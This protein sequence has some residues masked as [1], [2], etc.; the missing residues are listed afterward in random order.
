MTSRAALVRDEI[1][2]QHD[3][4]RTRLEDIRRAAEVVVRAR[5]GQAPDLPAMLEQLVGA[6]TA[7]M[8][9]EN[10]HLTPLLQGRNPCGHRYAALL[11]EEHVRQREELLAIVRQATDPDDLISLALAVAAFAAD[12]VED[13]DEE[14]LQFLTPHLLAEGEDDDQHGPPPQRHVGR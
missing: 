10:E 12:V 9:F 2:A 14:E 5:S 7:H 8:A 6:L 13:M 4:L 11:V 1:L 3:G